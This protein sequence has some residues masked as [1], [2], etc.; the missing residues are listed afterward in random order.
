MFSVQSKSEIFITVTLNLSS[1]NAFILVRSKT[2]S[3]GKELT[4]LASLFSVSK[5]AANHKNTKKTENKDKN[6]ETPSKTSSQFCC[7][8]MKS[9][10]ESRFEKGVDVK[11][12]NTDS[13]AFII[14]RLFVCMVFNANFNI[15]S[16]S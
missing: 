11:V 2:S 16:I 5:R 10:P 12:Q 3:F 4:L 13:A 9:E 6:V 14:L 1:A 15:I 8:L 7:W